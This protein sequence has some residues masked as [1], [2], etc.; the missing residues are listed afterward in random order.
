M[1]TGPGA[2]ARGCT[3]L[4]GDAGKLAG[5]SAPVS[6][7][8][9]SLQTSSSA[10]SSQSLGHATAHSSERSPSPRASAGRSSRTTAW[11]TN[12]RLHA[13]TCAI[14]CCFLLP[15]SSKG[16]ASRPGLHFEI[17][18]RVLSP[19]TWTPGKCDGFQ[20]LRLC[21]QSPGSQIQRVQ[22]GG[23]GRGGW[24]SISIRKKQIRKL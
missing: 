12:R 23:V 4:P 13:P 21:P 17:G 7:P 14:F 6:L 3:L 10:S 19:H 5:A 11:T 24:I 20:I 22:M 9:D 18:R 15:L 1:E 16:D 2:R 8:P